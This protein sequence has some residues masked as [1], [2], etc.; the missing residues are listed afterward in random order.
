MNGVNN[1]LDTYRHK[2]MRKKLID[3]LRDKG[4]VDE[5][6]LEAMLRV[7]R[8]LFFD[9]AFVD[10]SYED[11]AFPIGEG[12]TIS[13]PYTVA[14]QSSLLNVKR[15]EKVLEIGTGSGYQAAVLF[16]MGAKVFTVERQRKLFDKTRQ[17]LP[18]MGY[19]GI[20]LH[21]GDGFE[22]L[23]TFAPFDKILI[24]AGASEF[25]EKLMS[26]LKA[27]GLM[28]IPLGSDDVQYMKRFTRLP[29]GSFAEETFDTFKFVPLLHGKVNP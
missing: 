1:P 23:P 3:G 20:K 25:P 15:G 17:V 6:V 26:Q 27:G 21:Y 2:G 22:G 13:Q 7:P 5:N 14:Y 24:T 8:H 29:D 16:E 9:S 18:A 28:V 10:R 11:K 19:G 4:I 12:Q